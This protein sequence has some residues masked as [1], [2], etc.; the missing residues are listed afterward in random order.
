MSV[1]IKSASRLAISNL[2]A[3]Y[4]SESSWA[5]RTIEVATHLSKFA[6]TQVYIARRARVYSYLYVKTLQRFWLSPKIIYSRLLQASMNRWG[7][8]LLT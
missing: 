6:F 8:Q 7:R 2:V 1:P 4:V 3:D 5:I